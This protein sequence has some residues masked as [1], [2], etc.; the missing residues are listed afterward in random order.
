MKPAEPAAAV[1][2]I[3]RGIRDPAIVA[4]REFRVIGSRPIHSNRVLPKSPHIAA[5]N[6]APK[7]ALEYDAIPQPGAHGLEIGNAGNLHILDGAPF[8]L[9]EPDG[10]A[11]RLDHR[12][13]KLEIA[14]R[15]IPDNVSAVPRNENVRRIG[16]GL[17]EAIAAR[18][19]DLLT[20]C[21][22]C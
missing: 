20:G 22:D 9:A 10:R 3:A 6:A 18:S 13:E 21:G 1:D 14:E 8:G 4:D 16:S 11:G 19:E 17:D 12:G 5:S 15:H 2:A 7:R